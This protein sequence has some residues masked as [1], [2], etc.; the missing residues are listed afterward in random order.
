MFLFAICV[1]I[2]LPHSSIAVDWT[3]HQLWLSRQ[4]ANG[5]LTD[6]RKKK[7]KTKNTKKSQNL[8]FHFP[9]PLASLLSLTHAAIALHLFLRSFQPALSLSHRFV[10]GLCA[11]SQSSLSAPMVRGAASASQRIRWDVVVVA[12]SHWQT[13]NADARGI[14]RLRSSVFGLRSSLF[15]AAT[16][17]FYLI[18]A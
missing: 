7:H 15:D 8:K 16:R 17:L 2:W 18:G 3:C 9:I 5:F 11:L 12:F 14:D 10:H 4:Q 6:K 13:F 1:S